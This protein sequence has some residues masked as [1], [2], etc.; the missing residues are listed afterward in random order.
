MIISEDGVKNIKLTKHIVTLQIMK[1]I[2]NRL[3]IKIG[4]NK[5]F[6]D[7]IFLNLLYSS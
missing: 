2:Q 5:N 4:N 1:P 7:S 3:N 6:L